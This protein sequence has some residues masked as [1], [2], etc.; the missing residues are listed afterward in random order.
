MAKLGE[1]DERWIVKEREDGRNCNN[2]HW[3]SKDVSANTKADLIRTLTECTFDAPLALAKIKSAE[4]T[5]E[6]SVNNRK[7]KIFLIYDFEVRPHGGAVARARPNCSDAAVRTRVRQAS[8]TRSLR[9]CPPSHCPLR[10]CQLITRRRPRA[11]QVKLKWE[12]CDGVN[13][14]ESCK[15]SMTFSDVNATMLDDLDCEFK[16]KAAGALA[17]AMRKQ[18]VATVKSC[19]EA[20]MLRLQ[21]EVRAE[22]LRA[23]SEPVPE[24]GRANATP[25]VA[26]P[27]P[28]PIAVATAPPKPAAAPQAKASV[29]ADSSDEESPG[30]DAGSPPPALSDVLRRLRDQPE[31]TKEVCLANCS[32]RDAHLQVRAG[33]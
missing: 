8:P 15:G 18:G 6:A 4:V 17:S 31:Q 14:N 13:E 23:D 7:G 20:C 21:E 27:L 19:I 24:S 33:V 2:W 26:V 30:D 5:G 3:T 22:K 25:A 32:L 12:A 29:S 9:H 11:C 16:C 10:H 28:K 1:G